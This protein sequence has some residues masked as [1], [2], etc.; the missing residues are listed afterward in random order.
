MWRSGGICVL[1]FAFCGVS[2]AFRLEG[3]VGSLECSVDD[4]LFF[5][6]SFI[7]SFIHFFL[8]FFLSF[9]LFPLFPGFFL[10]L[11]LLEADVPALQAVA[12]DHPFNASRWSAVTR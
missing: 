9:L 1:R 6:H 8:S 2:F 7:H 11:P 3:M 5:F 10:F 4:V 12:G